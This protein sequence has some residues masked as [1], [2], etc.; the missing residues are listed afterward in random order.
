LTVVSLGVARWYTVKQP[1]EEEVLSA[2]VLSG[3]ERS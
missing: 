3:G 2:S 1:D